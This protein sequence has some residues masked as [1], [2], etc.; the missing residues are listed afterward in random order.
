[1][2]NFTIYLEVFFNPRVDGKFRWE[3]DLI[4]TLRT[5]VSKSLTE[6]KLFEVA[7]TRDDEEQFLIDQYAKLEY[8]LVLGAQTPLEVSDKIAELLKII[9]VKAWDLGLAEGHVIYE[10]IGNTP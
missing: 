7:K 9:R 5:Q 10:I 2:T 6:S 3:S 1:M 8:E 4:P